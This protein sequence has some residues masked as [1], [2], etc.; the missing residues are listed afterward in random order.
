MGDASEMLNYNLMQNTILDNCIEAIVG[1]Y[2][3]A[4]LQSFR[5]RNRLITFIKSIITLMS[6]HFSNHGPS[7]SNMK[8]QLINLP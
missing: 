2:V 7:F 8:F 6:W 3:G 5:M 1:V 4:Q